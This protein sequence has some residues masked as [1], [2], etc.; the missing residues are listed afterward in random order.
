MRIDNARNDM[1]DKPENDWDPRSDG[2]LKNQTAAYDEMRRRCPVAR[3][4]Y[5]HWSLFRH[6]D[7]M[8]VLEDPQTFSNAASTY[9]SIPNGM[10]PPQHT[11]YRQLLD[12]YFSTRRMQAFEPA[13]RD[14]AQELAAQLPRDGEI[15]FMSRF[16]R[17][18][19]LQIQ[20]AFLGWPPAWRTPLLE[21]IR[22]NR[23]AT[24]GA[25][26]AE[27][28]RVAL[29]FDGYIKALLTQR[30]A[31]GAA[32][33]DDITTSLLRAQIDQR[34]LQDEEIVSIVRNWTVGELGTIAACVGILAHYLA[35]HPSLQQ[36]LRAEPALL[37]D[38]IDE[39]LRIHAPLITNR[40]VTTRPVE[41]GGRH[42]PAGQRITIMWASANRDEAVFGTPDE[43]RPAQNA[44]R[45][46]LYG[47]GIHACPGAP[48]AR[49]ELRAI[50]QALLAHTRR[51][52]LVPGNPPVAE[53]YPGA[54]FA[55]LPLRI[56]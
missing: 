26:K 18:F 25:D 28:E 42:I 43:C 40:R 34:P 6:A 24:L 8:R 19:A 22:K 52:S 38:T 39:I 36:D 41:I 13:C 16:A 45:N 35:E 54:G 44:A 1:E 30:R 53:V 17:E 9:L 20:C 37:P 55:S 49:L 27:M 10:D 12:P 3:S 33:P 2:V 23:A 7:V 31:A 50:M 47:A 21:W 29:E 46:L 48:L 14:I 11:R 4:D 51:I 5:L 15:E 32:A 56:E